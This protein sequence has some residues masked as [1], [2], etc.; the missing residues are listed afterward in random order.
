MKKTL[1]DRIKALVPTGRAA[2]LAAYLS[3]AP[4]KEVNSDVSFG[5]G[6]AVDLNRNVSI[7]GYAASTDKAGWL[8]KIGLYYTLFGADKGDLSL[9]I[10]GGHLFEN[11]LLPSGEI[12]Y[13]PKSK[14]PYSVGV[15]LGYGLVKKNEGNGDDENGEKEEITDKCLSWGGIWIKYGDGI[16]CRCPEEPEKLRTSDGECYEL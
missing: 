16:E 9:K 11:G 7:G 3:V 12:V 15:G 8:G 1:T 4:A 5:G 6:I 10:G 13:T 14:N 2:A